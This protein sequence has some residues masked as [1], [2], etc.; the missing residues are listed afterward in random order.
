[1]QPTVV[2]IRLT[3][4]LNSGGELQGSTPF[5]EPDSHAGRVWPSLAWPG[6]GSGHARLSLACKSTVFHTIRLDF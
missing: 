1:M 6:V 3:F 5:R 2:G 4:D